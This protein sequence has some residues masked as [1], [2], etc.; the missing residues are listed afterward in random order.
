MTDISVIIP[1]YFNDSSIEKTINAIKEQVIGRNKNRTF[2]IICI[3]DG[4]EDTSFE[5][6]ERL[7]SE[8][9][10]LL[11]IIKFSRN[12]GQVQAMLAGYKMA[13]GQCVIN[14][15]ADLQ[16]PPM[17]MNEMIYAFF[18]ENV[19]IIIGTRLDRKESLY[20]KKTSH[21]FYKLIQKLSFPNMPVGGFDYALL[22]RKVVDVIL[23][24]K[25]SSPFW[26]GQILWTGFPVKFI[27]YIRSERESG[28]SRWTFSKKVK[29]LIDGVLSYSYFPLRA[30][31]ILGAILFFIGIIYALII[32][33]TYFFGEVPFNGWAPIMIIMLVLF[34]VVLLMLGVI[35]EYLWRVLE[36]VRGRLGYVI[37]KELKD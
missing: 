32:V 3:D 31:S 18:N 7:Y 20:R 13:K 37:E 15:S 26:Q 36:Q 5:V 30:I 33:A 24:N 16:D 6:L 8:N 12:F 27:P 25:D 21:F 17:L 34:G 11:K 2:E 28:K 22:G 29:Y 14:I 9:R 23:S 1:V 4:S 19:E 35:G 10:E